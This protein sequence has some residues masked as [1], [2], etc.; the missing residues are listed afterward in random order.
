MQSIPIPTQISQTVCAD[1]AQIV[2]GMFVNYFFAGF[3]LGK[4]RVLDRLYPHKMGQDTKHS[5]GSFCSITARYLLLPYFR[6]LQMHH[7]RS[8]GFSS[9]F[10]SGAIPTEPVLQ[11]DAAARHR[12]ALAGRHLHHLPLFLHPA[13]LWPARRFHAGLQVGQPVLPC[14]CF[15]SMANADSA[16]DGVGDVAANA[17]QTFERL[18]HTHKLSC[19]SCSISIPS[20]L[21]SPFPSIRCNP[22]HITARQ[23]AKRLLCLTCREETIDDTQLMTQKQAMGGASQMVDIAKAYEAEKQALDLV[24]FVG[25]LVGYIFPL[26][27]S[28]LDRQD[29]RRQFIC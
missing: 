5:S 25:H 29:M 18:S 1:A 16:A 11:A 26:H 20:T 17:M 28:L 22:A 27:H 13:T 24:S 9:C 7:L 10:S 2:M 21:A 3:I 8:R 12:A 23:T 6:R 4:V 14:L 19:L 15:E